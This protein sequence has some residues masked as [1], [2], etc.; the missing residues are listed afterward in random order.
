MA[1]EKERKMKK[2]LFETTAT[3]KPYNNKK[4]WIDSGIVRNIAIV[5]E[6]VNA[7]LKAYCETV[8]N[9]YCID[10]SN[11]ALKNKS[12]MYKDDKSGNATQCGYVLTAKTDF[13]NDSRGWVTQ[14]M[15]LWVTIAI[16]VNPFEEDA[17]NAEKLIDYINEYIKDC[18]TVGDFENECYITAMKD[19]LNFIERE[20]E[21]K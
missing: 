14:Y 2:F 20:N 6:D 12:P 3:M 21:K 15:E 19:V 18:Q 10:I 8:K 7:A 16:V 11:N 1:G 17:N 13:D 5:A 9:Q 4:W